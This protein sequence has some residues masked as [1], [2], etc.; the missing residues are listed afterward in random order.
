MNKKQEIAWP[1]TAPTQLIKT[2][3]SFLA[4]SSLPQAYLFVGSSAAQSQSREFV[5]TFAARITDQTFPNVDAVLFDAA[6]D[7]GIDGVREV[8]G[9]AALMP[10]NSDRKVVLMLNMDQASPQMLSALLKTL[11]QPPAHAYFILLSSRPLLATIMSRCQVFTL[12]SEQGDGQLSN[13]QAI[14]AEL[15]APLALLNSHRT[16]GQAERMVLVN[17]LANLEDELLQQ[18]LQVWLDQQV[19]EMCAVPQKYSAVRATIET[20][21]SL[22]RNFN[23]KIVLQQFVIAGLV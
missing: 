7:M 20:L 16:L 12:R 18:V 5:E 1:K 3:K 2:L 11:E 23:K 17:E 4:G 15:A 21:Q 22:Q 6:N 19:K 13:G 14:S 8:L 10:V 9:L